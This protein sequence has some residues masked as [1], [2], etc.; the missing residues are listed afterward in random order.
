MH[1]AGKRY[2]SKRGT[3]SYYR[4]F[5]YERKSCYR[6]VECKIACTS[7]KQLKEHL[8]GT[9]HQALLEYESIKQDTFPMED[10]VVLDET[11][12]ELPMAS[13]ASPASCD[14]SDS[15]IAITSA[16]VKTSAVTAKKKIKAEELEDQTAQVSPRSVKSSSSKPVP[17]AEA[18]PGTSKKYSSK[19]RYAERNQREQNQ[20]IKIF[21]VEPIENNQDV[22]KF[23]KTFAVANASDVAFAQKVKEMFSDALKKYEQMKMEEMY[24]TEAEHGP[25]EEATE[26]SDDPCD[27]EQTTYS[28]PQAIKKS[29]CERIHSAPGSPPNS[30]QS[31]PISIRTSSVDC[32][33][34]LPILKQS[35]NPDASSV[36]SRSPI[37][38]CEDT[39]SKPSATNSTNRVQSSVIEADPLMESEDCGAA[40][41][42]CS[43]DEDE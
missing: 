22:Y 10:M 18:A 24:C 21:H 42:A 37:Y 5:A 27:H 16:T 33:P 20:S 23:L 40:E 14:S 39:S 31:P 6:C 13:A 3:S 8:S 2:R 19:K 36:A 1:R 28:V 29:D 17:K 15:V 41:A 25:T 12:D 9:R 38:I 35:D 26:A 4:S 32:Q 43:D 30:S 34:G 11:D 7:F